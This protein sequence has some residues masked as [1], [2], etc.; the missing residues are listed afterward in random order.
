MKKM[1]AI[2]EIY[3]SSVAYLT[4]LAWILM[5][6]DDHSKRL[7]KCIPD[8]WMTQNMYPQHAVINMGVG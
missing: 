7:Q 6:Y 4:T 1:R 8:T 2:F 5:L 3:L